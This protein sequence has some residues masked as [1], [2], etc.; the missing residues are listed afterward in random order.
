MVE[1]LAVVG[2]AILVTAGVL[3]R[4]T[5]SR[6]DVTESADAR[7]SVRGERDGTMTVVVTNPGAEAVVVTA[8]ARPANRLSLLGR[9]QVRR[10]RSQQERRNS[11]RAA[12]Q[13]LGSVA[14]G[15]RSTWTVVGDASTRPV[16]R[17]VLSLYQA[18]GRVRVHEQVVRTQP[19]ALEVGFAG[20]RAFTRRRL[21]AG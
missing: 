13:L 10:S 7:S 15:G 4:H 2:L 12:R 16:C 3:G 1:L 8:C 5:W 17:V 6:R 19:S 21:P 14:P 11:S 9:D 18:Q 20:R